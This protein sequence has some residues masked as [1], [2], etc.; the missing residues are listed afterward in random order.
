[1][2]IAA[3]TEKRS[4]SLLLN[5]VHFNLGVFEQE[6]HDRRVTKKTSPEEGSSVI[7]WIFPVDFDL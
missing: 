6:L 7:F 4:G 2:T 3:S 1:V 5:F